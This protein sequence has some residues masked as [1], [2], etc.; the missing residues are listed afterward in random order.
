MEIQKKCSYKK[1]AKIEAIFYCIEC[2]INLC[3]KC[4]NHHSELFENH[5]IYDLHKNYWHMF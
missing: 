2:K 4:S 1:H 5:H 3:N